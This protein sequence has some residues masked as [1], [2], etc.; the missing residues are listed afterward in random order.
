[1][2]GL[3]TD[4]AAAVTH[5]VHH[6]VAGIDTSGATDAG[7]LQAIADIDARG[8]HLHAQ[9]A[10][11]AIT[12]PLGT[13]I[14]AFLAWATG[15]AATRVVGHGQGVLVEHH[16]LEACIRAHVQAHR[17]A[18]PAGIDIGGRREEQHPEQRHA[19]QLQGEQFMGQG[20][21]GVK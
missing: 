17:L 12:Q 16:T 19:A 10:I 8:A 11:D 7:H 6:V 14:A 3:V 21:I 15:F 2:F 18:Q 13:G 5:L 9:G 4:Q 20:R 1:M